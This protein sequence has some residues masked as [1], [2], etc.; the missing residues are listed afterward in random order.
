MFMGSCKLPLIAACLSAG[1]STGILFMN[2]KNR[3]TPYF[4]SII[5]VPEQF[6]S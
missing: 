3:P 1:G 6:F 5:A 2:L 4:L